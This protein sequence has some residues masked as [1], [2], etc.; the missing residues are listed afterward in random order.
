MGGR[1]SSVDINAVA[2]FVTL[3]DGRQPPEGATSSFYHS[4]IIT[5]KAMF[6]D[7]LYSNSTGLQTKAGTNGFS[8]PKGVYYN[9]ATFN[10]T[11]LVI[12]STPLTVN[13]Y[14]NSID[15][16]RQ[17]YTGSMGLLGSIRQGPIFGG[18]IHA[19]TTNARLSSSL[20]G[21]FT[22]NSYSDGTITIYP[23]ISSPA[24]ENNL[25]QT[26]A[27]Q[28]SV[29]LGDLSKSGY[30]GYNVTRIPKV[31]ISNTSFTTPQ[32]NLKLKLLV[33]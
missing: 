25:V 33:L 28:P 2:G 24:G 6:I 11:R 10:T 18:T 4:D 8:W 20:T 29:Y 15:Y 30:T 5:S 16:R 26:S 1:W 9:N 27:Y 17:V 32:S 7:N 22:G 21:S 13:A 19:P 31:A 14:Y 12:P 23:L 3:D